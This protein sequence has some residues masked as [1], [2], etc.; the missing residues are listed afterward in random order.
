MTVSELIE[1][2]KA[3]PSDMEVCLYKDE[4]SD[5]EW[6][7]RDYMCLDMLMMRRQNNDR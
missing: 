7:D 3:Y 2:L 6:D 5:I 1:Q 4:D